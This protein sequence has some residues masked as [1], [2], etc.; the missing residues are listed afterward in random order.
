[1]MIINDSYIKKIFNENEYTSFI[2]ILIKLQYFYDDLFTNK[3][4]N[5][6]L[7]QKK[8]NQKLNS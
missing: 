2:K 1:M 4:P 5:F 3:K 8:K 7:K 6:F